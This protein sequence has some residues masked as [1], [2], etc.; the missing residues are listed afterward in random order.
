MT[1]TTSNLSQRKLG[2]LY[3]QTEEQRLVFPLK[4]TEVEAKIAGHLSRV[5]VRQT[6]DN[7]FAQ[8]L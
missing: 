3:V 6:F 5:E 2:G 4:H 7:P 1:T 8:D